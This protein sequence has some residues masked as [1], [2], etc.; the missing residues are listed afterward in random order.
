M[1]FDTLLQ[2]AVIMVCTRGGSH[3]IDIGVSSNSVVMRVVLIYINNTYKLIMSNIFHFPLTTNSWKEKSACP[4]ILNLFQD[5]KTKVKMLKWIQHDGSSG[6]PGFA[7]EWWEPNSRK[8][9]STRGRVEN[10]IFLYS[11]LG[12]LNH[13]DPFFWKRILN[14]ETVFFQ[15]HLFEFLLV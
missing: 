12:I 1:V 5:P 13:I 14:Y 6:L 15:P 4:V 7:C 9:K 11:S 8:E 2:L 10:S 3:S